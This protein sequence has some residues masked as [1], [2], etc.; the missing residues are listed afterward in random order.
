M[1]SYT[2]TIAALQRNIQSRERALPLQHPHWGSQFWIHPQP[3]A[4][5]YL[6][7]HGFTAV[8]A[9]WAGLATTLHQAGANV[10]APLLPGHGR[11]GAWSPAQ[12]PPLPLN[13][14]GYERFA[15]AWL[16]QA[17]ALGRTV[18]VGGIGS[19]GT[20]AIWLALQQPA[21]IHRT[22][23]IAPYLQH[24]DRVVELFTRRMRSPQSSTHSASEPDFS[25]LEW[26]DADILGGAA[27][28]AR[29]YP[30]FSQSALT[31]FL[32]LGA[33]ILSRSQTQPI[34]PL[35]MLASESD[36]AI[37]IT[38]QHQLFQQIV[39][40]CPQSWWYSCPQYL[41][42][43]HRW[44]TAATASDDLASIAP[45]IQAFVSSDLTWA[46]LEALR[47]AVPPGEDLETALLDRG[48][49]EHI[50]PAALALLQ[51]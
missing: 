18:I 50:S 47:Q 6:F 9:Q 27:D 41:D 43:A 25:Y 30:G 11:S 22:L 23:A 5:T 35:L 15:I 29:T 38:D 44:H 17:Q 40:H 10:L 20:L 14:T 45:V 8:P 46:E 24:S 21:A 2:A 26:A 37:G 7:F 34:A 48:L 1:A 51:V 42:L 28:P 49:S 32:N 4:L 36:R 39:Q 31:P 33:D 19:G 16:R 3:R 13:A 12:P